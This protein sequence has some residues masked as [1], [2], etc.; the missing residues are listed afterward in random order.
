M[1]EKEKMIAGEMYDPMD[2]EL[3]RDRERAH[4]LCYTYNQLA[5]SEKSRKKDI[6]K[7]LFN[8]EK[9]CYIEP[10]FRCD[11]GYNISF[12]KNFYMNFDCV[13]LDVNKVTIGNNVMIAPKVQIYTATHPLNPQ[14][15]NSGR[16]LG[17]PIVIGDNVWIGGGAI[18]CP[19]VTIGD[20]AVI[21]AGAVVTKDVEENV[22]VGGNPAKFI[23]SIE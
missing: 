20:N 15:R 12:G 13:I 21:A 8:T 19:G 3:K 23:K 4:E 11:Y 2:Q 6:L 5:P 1:T 22:L 10:N 16:E 9:N 17:Y 18:I 14:R 7:K